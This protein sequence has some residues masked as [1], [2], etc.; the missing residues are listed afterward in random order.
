MQRRYVSAVSKRVLD[1]Y[2][3]ISEPF[4][5]F[6]RRTQVQP[7]SVKLSHFSIR[8][9]LG[10]P[11]TAAERAA[12]EKIPLTQLE[13]FTIEVNGRRMLV[14]TFG[15]SRE[16]RA[17]QD[18]Y[19]QPQ[20]VQSAQRRYPS[21]HTECSVLK[22]HKVLRIQSKRECESSIHTHTHTHTHTYYYIHTYVLYRLY[23]YVYLY[24]NPPTGSLCVWKHR[25]CREH[26]SS[27]SLS[28]RRNRKCMPDNAFRHLADALTRYM[29]VYTHSS[30]YRLCISWMA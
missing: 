17:P 21:R 20:Q 14:D 13:A 30:M 27:S 3:I 15:K 12:R 5:V 4:F 19:T 11:H 16:E 10:R 25:R 29:R 23:I 22:T 18:R 7:R 8:D 6:T 2:I 24:V 26:M 28:Y 9:L 1:T